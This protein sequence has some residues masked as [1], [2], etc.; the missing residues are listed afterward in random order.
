M[1]EIVTSGNVLLQKCDT[2]C[3][4]SVDHGFGCDPVIIVTLDHLDNLLVIA[5]GLGYNANR[6]GRS[7]LMAMNDVSIEPAQTDEYVVKLGLN[8][9]TL[10]ETDMEYLM[11]CLKYFDGYEEDE[12]SL[13]YGLKKD[14]RPTVKTVRDGKPFPGYSP[15]IIGD[16]FGISVE[17]DDLIRMYLLGDSGDWTDIFTLDG[18]DEVCH[19]KQVF[20][21]F[22]DSME[23]N[24][25]LY[26]DTHYG[27]FTY[28]PEHDDHYVKVSIGGELHLFDEEDVSDLIQ[29]ISMI[30]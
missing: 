28:D 4:I 23:W 7:G 19:I 9:L 25:E 3:I 20:C 11:K 30:A 26:I 27:V 8:S 15:N 13:E 6:L 21:L 22:R 18:G 17:K 12:S 16:H 1:C 2:S 24:D 10:S 14:D 29:V 5:K